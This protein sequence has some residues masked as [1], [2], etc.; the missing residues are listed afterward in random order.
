[1]TAIDQL[2]ELIQ[3]LLDEDRLRSAIDALLD[4]HELI[5][6][7]AEEL[8]DLEKRYLAL[9]EDW[10]NGTIV[11]GDYL[12]LRDFLR[13]EILVTLESGRALHA[14]SGEQLKDPVLVEPIL[15]DDAF[16]EL[17]PITDKTQITWAELRQKIRA[18]LTHNGLIPA[19]TYLSKLLWER[20]TLEAITDFQ[21]RYATFIWQ[22]NNAHLNMQEWEQ[23]YLSLRAELETLI[24]TLT[25]ADLAPNW[26]EAHHELIGAFRLVDNSQLFALLSRA[27]LVQVPEQIVGEEEQQ[28][29][30]RLMYLYQDAF[31]VGN[32]REAYAYCKQ[33]QTELEVES[34]QL[35]EYLLL[36]YFKLIGEETII[37]QV[38]EGRREGEDDHLKHLLTYA[39]RVR[40]L[41]DNRG[42]SAKPLNDRKHVV[43]NTIYSKTGAYNIQQVLGGLAIRFCEVYSAID[44]HYLANDKALKEEDIRWKRLT[45]CLLL[46]R[47]LNRFVP[48]DVIYAQMVVQ[49]LA[50]GGKNSWIDLS[51]D[52]ELIN[53]YPGFDALRLIEE[54]KRMLTFTEDTPMNAQGVWQVDQAAIEKRLAEDLLYSLEERFYAIKVAAQTSSH[55]YS[56]S[57]NAALVRCMKAFRIAATLFPG[58]GLFHDLVIQELTGADEDA[59]RWFKFNPFGQLIQN[60]ALVSVTA[61]DALE[62]LNYHFAQQS[63]LADWEQVRSD[64]VRV[65][66]KR[67]VGE[68]RSIYEQI[69]APKYRVNEATYLTVQ[70]IV[71]CL[72]NW[73]TLYYVYQEEPHL[74]NCLEELLGNVHFHWFAVGRR[75]LVAQYL[76]NNLAFDA[77]LFLDRILREKKDVSEQV[78]L[79][80]IAKNY[81]NLYIA[82]SYRAL[83]KKAERTGPLPPDLKK[84]LWTLLQ[85][86]TT[87]Y[88]HIDADTRYKDF[89]LEE[90]SKERLLRYF[91]VGDRKIIIHTDCQKMN[92][93]PMQLVTQLQSTDPSDERLD[94]EHLMMTTVY[95]RRKDW[96]AEYDTEF[97]RVK[98]RNY[99]DEDRLRMI[100]LIE[101]FYQGYLITKDKSFLEIPYREYV[102]NVGKIRWGRSLLPSL[103]HRRPL[104]MVQHWRNANLADFSFRFERRK[105]YL[106]YKEKSWLDKFRWW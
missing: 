47:S 101:R 61:F 30:K 29:Y 57:A 81:F 2:N 52:Q 92:F 69:S 76:P 66:Y 24:N 68:T 27:D 80:N 43:H 42:A 11:R 85:E 33:M 74:D 99:L 75:E 12:N 87:L 7:S 5:G 90:L 82:T 77:R 79:H 50:G 102:L 3:G 54:A 71:N 41:Q 63:G 22:L 48:A 83:V 97:H 9:E 91:D 4:N 25:E 53:V 60:E 89:V 105:V 26:R 37:R 14:T 36:S 6:A 10:E 84:E 73:L 15:G 31:T 98:R 72:E 13:A 35:Y 34:A 44:F 58:Q 93:D 94:P 39:G 19:V 59:L 18:V 88:V 78:C 21:K 17:E 95:N 62:H 46:T 45:N 28:R 56:F 16:R 32:Y 104:L 86:A 65:N 106:A 96:E 8:I 1:M 67:L 40:A 70:Q 38:L 55:E 51:P 100:E 20:A 64:L 23:G 103:S 49:E